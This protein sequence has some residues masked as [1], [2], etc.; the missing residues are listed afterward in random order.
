MAQTR[1]AVRPAVKVALEAASLFAGK[2]I[3]AILDDGTKARAAEQEQQLQNPGAVI[4]VLPIMKGTA[5]DA[6]RG[7]VNLRVWGGIHIRI[8]PEINAQPDRAQLDLDAAIDAAMAALLAKAIDET[9]ALF[10]L[11]LGDGDSTD[12]LIADTGCLTAAVLFS[13]PV[14]VPL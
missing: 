8:N 1:A 4:A 3:L 10:G 12:E 5:R 13:V 9:S 6:V 14:T 11:E 2:Q 7:R